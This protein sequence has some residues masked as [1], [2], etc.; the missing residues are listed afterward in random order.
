MVLGELGPRHNRWHVRDVFTTLLQEVQSADEATYAE[1]PLRGLDA[2]DL[3]WS[4][5]VLENRTLHPMLQHAIEAVRTR[6]DG[7]SG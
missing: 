4:L 3:E 7:S 6:R 2:N 5:E 1:E